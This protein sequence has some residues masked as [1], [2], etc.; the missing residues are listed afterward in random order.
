M[1]YFRRVG[2]QRDLFILVHKNKKHP[3][4]KSDKKHTFSDPVLPIGVTRQNFN[5]LKDV[6]M[7]T[8]NFDV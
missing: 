1:K 4:K 3:E 6:V 8:Q 2:H 5:H 7:Q